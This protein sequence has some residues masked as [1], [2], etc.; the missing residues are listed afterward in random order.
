MMPGLS[1]IW[2]LYPPHQL[3][4]SWTPSDKTFWIRALALL[5]EHLKYQPDQ[6]LCSLLA[7][8]CL[9]IVEHSE[10]F[11]GNARP[12]SS[13]IAHV[14]FKIRKARDNYDCYMTGEN[15]VS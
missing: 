4:L 13:I 3:N 9:L 14:H 10:I 7:G 11:A 12:S 1:G 2:I 6:R 5:L 15:P 8:H